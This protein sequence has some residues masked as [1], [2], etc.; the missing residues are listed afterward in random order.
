MQDLWEENYK[1]LLMDVNEKIN[2]WRDISGFW[3]GRLNSLKM[4]IPPQ[5]IN[6][7]KV[8]PMGFFSFNKIILDFILKNQQVRTA[9]NFLNVLKHYHTIY[10]ASGIRINR[11]IEPNR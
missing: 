4:T 9:N 6:E 7:F 1:P 2:K 5:L 10:S 3:I 11:S 8:T